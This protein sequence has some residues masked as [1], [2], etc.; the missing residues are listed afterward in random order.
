[1]QKLKRKT[2]KINITGPTI[3]ENLKKT[4]FRL[5]YNKLDQGRNTDP[6]LSIFY[7][8]LEEGF[9]LLSL[10]ERIIVQKELKK[11]NCIIRQLTGSLEKALE[12][13]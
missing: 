4:S 13:P 7:N 12:E 9:M 1:M 10:E 3:T 5:S 6:N 11:R 2:P 8:R